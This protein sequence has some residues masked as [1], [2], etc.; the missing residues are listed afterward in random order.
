MPSHAC[1]SVTSFVSGIEALQTI[2]Q[3]IPD[4]I[5]SDIGMPRIDGY[6]LLQQVRNLEP[7][8]HIPAIALT[9]CAGEFDRQQ[10]LQAGFQ[11]HLSKPIDPNQLIQAISDLIEG[12]HD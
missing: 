7:V 4:F 5:A 2:G 8:K 11:K 9:A 1:V 3:A 12:S 10:A 6:S